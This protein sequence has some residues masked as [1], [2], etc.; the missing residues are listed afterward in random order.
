M[1]RM[2]RFALG[3]DINDTS[4][5]VVELRATS[6]GLQMGRS[7]IASTPPGSIREGAIVDSRAVARAVKDLLKLGR[8]RVRDRTVVVSL[9]GSAAVVRVT[10]VPDGGPNSVRE[11][12]QQEIRRYAAFTGEKTVS[13]YTVV[14]ASRNEGKGRSVLR[15][16]SKEEV[17]NALIRTVMKAGLIPVAIDVSSLATARAIY[18]KYLAVNPSEAKLI[19]YVESTAIH[20]LIFRSG[21][22][23]FARTLARP[24]S[25]FEEG[26]EG[27]SPLAAEIRSVL[28]FYRTEISDGEPAS[29]AILCADHVLPEGLGERISA[30]LEGQRVAICSP[31]SV[32]SDAGLLD[33]PSQSRP[34]PCAIGLA[35]RAIGD[36]AFPFNL[37]LLPLETVQLQTL[38]RRGLITAIL[39][40]SLFLC[41]GLAAMAARLSIDAVQKEVRSMQ[42]AVAGLVLPPADPQSA[43]GVAQNTE[44]Q[45]LSA[46]LTTRRA[47]LQSQSGGIPWPKVLHEI[48][49][50][51]PQDV[52][53]TSLKSERSGG[54]TLE[55][56]SL[57]ILSVYRFV[58]LLEESELVRAAQLSAART[59]GSGEEAVSKYTIVCQLYTEGEQRN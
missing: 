5:S 44:L 42:K 36:T 24:A 51:I 17:A 4:L 54:I 25:L 29:M 32:I 21:G 58:E 19:V 50:R 13:D 14:E 9:S 57:S 12:L 48:R 41:A 27:I 38:K 56:E 16:A 55:G 23:C 47:V 33:D 10:Q 3:L 6:K 40:A 11:H 45:R 59:S 7:A 8:I 37:N 52:R 43:A 22:I 46:E 31:P 34:T 30:A 2:R 35:M 28:D 20:S 15:A 26:P 39:V 1:R 18:K 53:V 49:R